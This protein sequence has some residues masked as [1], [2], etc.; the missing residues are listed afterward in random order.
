MSVVL[1]A[2]FCA[3]CGVVIAVPIHAPVSIPGRGTLAHRRQPGTYT[4][5]MD[6]SDAG[7]AGASHPDT[8]TAGLCAACEHVGLVRSARGSTFLR[9]G[10]HDTVR[11]IPAPAG[12]RVCW[13]LTEEGRILSILRSGG[14]IEA[15]P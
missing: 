9:C 11:A 15:S 8:R 12:D 2:V 10:M 7:A 5:L 1:C 4:R 3:V 14:A 13:I 6:L